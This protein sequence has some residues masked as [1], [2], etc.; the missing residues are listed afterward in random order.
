MC[1]LAEIGSCAK[2]EPIPVTDWPSADHGT[3]LGMEGEPREDVSHTHKRGL[4]M[5]EGWSLKEISGVIMKR[6]E[7]RSLTDGGKS[8]A[9]VVLKVWSLC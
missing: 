7:R 2:S 8:S 3:I 9:L 1:S 6:S 5:E 4:R